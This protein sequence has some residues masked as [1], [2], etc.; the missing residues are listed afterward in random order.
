VSYP[1]HM[2]RKSR[3]YAPRRINIILESALHDEAVQRADDLG[4]VGGF[5]EYVA[6]LILAD[7]RRKG[8]DVQQVNL[9]DLR[10]ALP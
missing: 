10:V 3:Y 6:R 7:R 9:S 1:Y 4:F 2:P 8:R 5:S